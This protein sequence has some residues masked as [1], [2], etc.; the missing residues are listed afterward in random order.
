MKILIAIDKFKDCLSAHQVAECLKAGFNKA[1]A[2]FE[3]KCLPIADGGEGTVDVLVQA[4][5]GKLVVCQVHDPLMRKIQAQYGIIKN[6]TTAVIEMAAAS[7]LV[8]L[9]AQERNPWYTSTVGT[10]E[11][12][13]D[14]YKRGCTRFIIGIGGSATNDAGVGMAKALG[15]T[16]TNQKGA[17]IGNGGGVLSELCTISKNKMFA[18]IQKL[19]FIVACDVSNPLTGKNGASMVYSFQKGASEAMAEMLDTNL[20]HF[21]DIVSKQLGIDVKNIPGSG[22]AGGLGAGFLAFLNARLENGFEIIRKETS[23]D[24]LCNW[25]D[26]VI[27]GEGKLDYQTAFGKA[28]LGV[29]RTARLFNKPVIG[30]AGTLGDGYSELCK[31]DFDAIF[32]I[33]T[34]PVTLDEAIQNAP[35]LL[36]ECA[37]SIGKTILIGNQIK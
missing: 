28:P 19:E 33:L 26:I 16:F 30:V 22:A 37:Y 32:S 25:A 6:G 3:V 11:L 21:S 14:A 34:K 12:I 35:F 27:T 5:E 2:T 36:E 10:G 13:Q 9:S 15:I 31:L 29:A 23:L 7:G 8:L 18:D 1:S 20:V 24:E 17:D 4:L